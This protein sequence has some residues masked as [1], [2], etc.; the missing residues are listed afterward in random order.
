MGISPAYAQ[1]LPELNSSAENNL[2]EFGYQQHPQ[3]LLENTKGVIQVYV[4]SGDKIVPTLIKG[5]KVTSSD[6]SII[7]IQEIQ[8]DDNEYSTKIS[9]KRL[10]ATLFTKE[11]AWCGHYFDGRCFTIFHYHRFYFLRSY[12][13]HGTNNLWK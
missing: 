5:M 13:Y 12:H 9:L 1:I 3:K 6:N 2:Y 10:L 4:L 8:S 11:A 7:Q